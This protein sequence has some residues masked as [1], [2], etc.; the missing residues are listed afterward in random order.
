MLQYNIVSRE[1]YIF[2]DLTDLN[3]Y[4]IA[5]IFKIAEK[6]CSIIAKTVFSKA[7]ERRRGDGQR[8]E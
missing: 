8:H 5:T 7:Q 2:S 6:S 4:F 3:T 1:K